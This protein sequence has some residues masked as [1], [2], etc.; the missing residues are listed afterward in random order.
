MELKKANLMVH[1]TFAAARER[2]R[3]PEGAAV[4]RGV[5]AAAEPRLVRLANRRLGAGAGAG[6]S[7]STFSSTATDAAEVCCQ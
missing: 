5:C 3:G 4:G 2:V 6:S 7:S 1:Q